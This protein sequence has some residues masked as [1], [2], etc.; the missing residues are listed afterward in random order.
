MRRGKKSAAEKRAARRFEEF[1]RSIRRNLRQAHRILGRAEQ[2][3]RRCYEKAGVAMLDAKMSSAMSEEAFAAWLGPFG[4]SQDR[5][6]QCLE[7]GQVELDRR[8][9]DASEREE[10]FRRI[11]TVRG[12]MSR[13]AVRREEEQWARQHEESGLRQQS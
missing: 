11:V 1:T 3:A 7:L 6:A 9:A 5:L 4:L 2:T 10:S 12:N 13:E 8:K